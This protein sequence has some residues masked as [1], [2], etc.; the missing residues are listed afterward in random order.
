MVL[1]T[2]HVIALICVA[3]AFGGMIFFM[4]A[5]AP[6]VFRTL[7]HPQATRITRQVF[8]RYYMN[9]AELQGAG[10]A[11]L[12]PAHSYGAKFSTLG[13]TCIVNLRPR[14]FLLRRID[15]VRVSGP[16]TFSRLHRLS[17]N[18]NIGLFA[19]VATVLVR[20]VQ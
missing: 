20:L 1:I 19:A 8:P 18:K 4:M 14:Q 3:S 12:L 16:A 11:A 2:L 13:I 6:S 7:E 17:V 5:L 10:G 9:L 15:R